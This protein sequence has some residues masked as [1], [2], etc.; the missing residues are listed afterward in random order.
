MAPREICTERVR[1]CFAC[2]APDS[3][4][5][6]GMTEEERWS[7]VRQIVREEN[8][9]LLAEIAKIVGS[10]NKKTIEF[11][12]GRW[13]G[14]TED[15]MQA[16]KE[17][18]GAVDID[19]ELKKMAAWMVSNP[20]LAPAKQVGRFVNS[21]L[22]KSQNSASLRSIP[23]EPRKTETPKKLCVY[24]TSIAAGQVG[25]IWACDPHWQKA[26]DR[27]PIPRMRGVEAKQ[28][29]GSD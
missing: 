20:H 23:L 14:V 29:A 16:W 25:G 19:A 27:D 11:V 28:V 4:R 15:Q 21:W 22:A 1:G 7:K 5:E 17:A 2:F 12:N 3:P 9:A 24:C 8:E 6:I 13:V 26:M 18:Y 10:K